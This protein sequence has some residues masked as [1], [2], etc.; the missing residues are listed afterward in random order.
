MHRAIGAICHTVMP[1]EV[2]HLEP[3]LNVDDVA[4]AAWEPD[5]GCV[6]PLAATFSFV[7]AGRSLGVQVMED[8]TV[9][10]LTIGGGHI[11]G[12]RTERGYLNTPVVVNAAGPW[13]VRVAQMAEIGAPIANER[14][15]VGVFGRPPELRRPHVAVIDEVKGTYFRPDHETAT[16]VG[17][18]ARGDAANPDEFNRAVDADFPQ[19]ARGLLAERM[20][21]MQRAVFRG[22]WSGIFDITPDG[23]AILGAAGPEGFFMACGFSGTGFKLAPAV[24]ICLSE[25]ILTGQS[26]TVDISPFRLSRYLERQPIRG[27]WEYEGGSIAP[28]SGQ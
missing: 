13:A 12:L 28:E 17:I 27:E 19:R 22:G 18:D 20:P 9:V 8:T 6:D 25:L 2:K 5:S 24:G 4:V 7:E 11:V 3:A 14:R 1:M 26:K 21:G 23:K 10:D 16:L 15:Q